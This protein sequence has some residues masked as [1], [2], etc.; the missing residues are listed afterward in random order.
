MCIYINE[1]SRLFGCIRRIWGLCARPFGHKSH[2]K[3][4]TYQPFACTYFFRRIGR[5]QTRTSLGQ[6]PLHIRTVCL[7][8]SFSPEQLATDLVNRLLA[9]IP[10][11]P[12]S[13]LNRSVPEVQYTIQRRIVQFFNFILYYIHSI[14][15]SIILYCTILYIILSHIILYTVLSQHSIVQYIVLCCILYYTFIVQNSIV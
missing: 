11:R 8:I 1:H 13:I 5:I 9:H 10:F 15:H 12:N 3:E 7:H 14:G 2:K 4:Y 6:A